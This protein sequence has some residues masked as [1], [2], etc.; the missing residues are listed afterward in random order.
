MDNKYYAPK[1]STK[2]ND[3]EKE[4]RWYLEEL[5]QAGWIKGF[6]REAETFKVM[7][8]FSH[9]REIHHKTKENALES[10]NL[11]RSIN[12]TYDFR[13]IWNDCSLNI[14][15]EL[16]SNKGH[17]RFGKPP[18]ISHRLEVAGRMEIVSYVDVKPHANAMARSGGKSA[19]YYTFPFVQK[20]LMFFHGL[21][22]NKII[23]SPSN[24]SDGVNTCLFATTFTPNRYLFTEG[25]GALRKLHH[26]AVTLNA[27]TL[28]KKGII[29]Q[30]IKAIEKKE[31]NNNQTGL[32]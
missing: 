24:K 22:I 10:F 11:L 20:I 30:L 2:E 14:F 32:F 5:Q 23:P 21:Y 18:F 6:T 16:Y 26:R 25:G 1:T 27:F 4:F 17:F 3:G 9:L 12:Y 29:D 13:I 15:T 31:L 8:E 28:K 19:S 7:N